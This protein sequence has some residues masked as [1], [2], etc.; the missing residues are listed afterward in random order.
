MESWGE[1][2]SRTTHEALEVLEKVGA[3]DWV[4]LLRK[5]K[6]IWAE[7]VVNHA[8]DRWTSRILTWSPKEGAR[9]VGHPKLRWL[10]PIQ[11]FATSLSGDEEG[12]AW[13][14]LLRSNTEARDALP[15]FLQYC[16]NGYMS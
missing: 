11:N 6:W 15:Q 1:W 10:D 8:G 7:K 9:F 4:A 16:E 5:R 13:I 12:D 14:Y 2:L 3:E